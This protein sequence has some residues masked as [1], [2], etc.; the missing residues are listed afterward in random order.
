MIKGRISTTLEAT[1]ARTAQMLTREGMANSF[2][3]RLVVE[4]LGDDTTFAYQLLRRMIDDHGV[5]VV[6]RRIVGSLIAQPQLEVNTAQ[7]H[8]TSMCRWID[9]VLDVKRISTVHILYAAVLDSTTAT[10]E[11][12]RGYGITAEDI[13]SEIEAM[14]EGELASNGSDNGKVS[15]DSAAEVVVNMPKSGRIVIYVN[16]SLGVAS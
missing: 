14:A 9:N 4:I 6:V 5:A 15:P 7:V 3:D 16:G 10:S 1:I 11:A 12:L 8:Y 2:T 13:L